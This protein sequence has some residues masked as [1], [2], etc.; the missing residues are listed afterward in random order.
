M[1][2]KFPHLVTAKG[3]NYLRTIQSNI[4]NGDL[5]VINKPCFTTEKSEYSKA[6]WPSKSSN[7][8]NIRNSKEPSMTRSGSSSST[9]PV[10]SSMLFHPPVENSD[11]YHEDNKISSFLT[12]N[13]KSDQRYLN[14]YCCKSYNKNDNFISIVYQ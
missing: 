4:L 1:K 5:H 8:D 10:E 2:N 3:K 7:K 14:E 11:P 12:T 9:L 13:C 6:N